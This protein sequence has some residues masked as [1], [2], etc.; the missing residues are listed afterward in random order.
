MNRR[1]PS[2][3]QRALDRNVFLLVV[4]A[5]T[6]AFCWV[7]LPY[8]GA[9]LWGS[10]LALLFEPLYVRLLG[11]MKGR[12]NLAAA[13]T[14]AIILVA[15]ILP[16]ALVGISLVK[17]V[18]GLYQRVRTGQVNFGAYFAQIVA[19]MPAWASTALERLGLDDLSLL[20][21]KV[22]AAITARG[23][24]L[25][26]RAVDIGGNMLDLV[27]E[28]AIA[29]YLLFFLLR[30]GVGLTRDI[31][32]AIPLAPAAKERVLERFTTVIR[33]TVKG[34]VLVA[35]AQGALGG[36]AFWFLGIHAAMLW[37]VIMAFLSLLPA[38]GAAL[39]WAP[40]AIYL[41]AVGQIGQGIALTLFGLFV[42]GLIDNV[43]RPILVGQDT[44]LPDY[45]V[46]NST[47]G[48][49]AVVGINGFVVGPLI[50]AM[51][52]AVWQLLAAERA[53]AT[54]DPA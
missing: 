28:F 40:V 16:L 37:A 4:V 18:T 25:A 11:R 15:V 44:Q 39:I 22:T 33:A 8:Y 47:V 31:R 43:M 41:F 32:A 46:L 21:A 7:I 19:A 36:V 3:P 38:V 9:V 45:V 54:A 10:A 26:G 35:A 23:E 12:R 49:I 14:L 53:E 42:I 2:A 17:E 24:E 5:L 52:V 29:M 13:A 34:N 20:Q 6:I 1:S 50:A 48:G 51:F 30:D 27:I